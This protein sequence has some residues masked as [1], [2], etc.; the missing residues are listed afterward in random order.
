M[1]G[2]NPHYFLRVPGLG[3]LVQTT[4]LVFITY[5]FPLSIFHHVHTWLSIAPLECFQFWVLPFGLQ[6]APAVFMQLINKVL[7]EHKG[8]LVYLG[9][10]L[11]YTET[12]AEHIKLV[13]S[14]L[15]K[16]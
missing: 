8:A 16:L 13:R 11:I 3:T 1:F 5:H 7:H 4:A 12:M 6:R 14:V 10:I 15:K 2:G 9:D